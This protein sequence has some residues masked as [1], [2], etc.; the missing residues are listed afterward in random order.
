MG[1]NYVLQWAVV[2][3]LEITAAGITVSYWENNVP[4]G[5]WI[6][7][8]FIAIIA[9]NVF[10]TLGYA[11]EEFWSSCLK[12]FVIVMFCFIAVI[13]N[14][15]GGPKSGEYGTYVGGRYWSDPG[16]FANGF[17][18]VCSVFVTAAFSFAGT[19]LVGL[20]ASETPNPRKTMP[21][22]IKNTFWRI[23][24]IYILSLLL[25]GLL[26]PYNDPDLLFGGGTAQ[27]SPFVRVLDRANIGGINHLINVTICVSCGFILQFYGIDIMA[28][29]L[30]YPS[31]CLA[32]MVDPVP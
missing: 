8:F 31:D 15:G 19:E 9:I 27:A 4:L 21:S 13:C 3:P 11:E 25:I 28:R 22:A 2:L 23:T 29:S 7:I 32:S 17:K 5:A 12:L 10:G 1:W 26:I 30:Y 6:T 24:I 18:G 20:A 14:A 16:P